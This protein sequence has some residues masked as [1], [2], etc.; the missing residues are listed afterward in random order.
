MMFRADLAIV[1]ALFSS[2]VSAA[3]IEN[4]KPKQVKLIKENFEH[5]IELCNWY[6]SG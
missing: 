5:P 4:C 3:Q 6:N 2:A 1:V